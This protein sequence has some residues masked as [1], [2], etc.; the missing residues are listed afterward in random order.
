MSS[1]RLGPESD[2][3]GK[4]QKQLYINKPV[5]SLK[6]ASLIKKP[7]IIKQEKTWSSALS[8]LTAGYKYGNLALQVR[9]SSIG[10]Q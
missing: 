7:A 6:K 8:P 3:A 4:A 5:L 1:V 2:C 10:R 9:G